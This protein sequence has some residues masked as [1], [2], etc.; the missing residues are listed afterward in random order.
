MYRM[1]RVNSEIKKAI[2]EI[3]QNMNDKRIADCF[4]TISYVET[5]PDLK[6]ARIGVQCEDGKT[7][8]KL[9]NN[10]K[11]FI[12][13]ELASKVKIKNTPELTFVVDD[14]ELK[15]QRIE[16]ILKKINN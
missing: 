3:I 9:L 7:I 2:L 8:V 1:D 4:I 15:A 13:R 12:R 10:S 14:T 16:E 6:T 5:A 11:S